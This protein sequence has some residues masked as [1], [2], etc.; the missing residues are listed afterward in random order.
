MLQGIECDSEINHMALQEINPSPER[1]K[2]SLKRAFKWRGYLIGLG[3]F[4]LATLMGHLV[5]T[6]FAP[7]NI[8]MIYLLCVTV[9]AVLGGLGPSI[10]VSILSA[11]TFDFFFITPYLTFAVDDTQYIF[12]FIALLLVGI[13]ISYLTSRVRQQTEAAKLRE[14]ETAALY[15]LGRD[16]A[17]SGDLESYIEAI[18]KRIKETLGHDVIIFLPDAQS[19][20]KLKAYARG[21]DAAI[22]RNELA[23]A[24]WSFQNQREA[25]YGTETLSN[26]KARYLPLVTVRGAIGVM[27]LRAPGTA[28]E[29]SVEQERLLRAY[30]DLV[31]VA[32]EGIQLADELHNAQVLKATEKLQAALLNAISHDLRTPLV[33]VIGTLS[34]LQEEGM[35]LDDA[36]KKNLIQVAREEADRLNHLITNLLDESRIE[37]GAITLSRQP[38]EVQD[39]VGAALEQLGS[40]A[41]TRSINID[42]PAEMPYISV[43]FGLIV[44]TLANILDNA[45]K[46]SP[47]DSPIE[48]KARQLDGDIHIEITDHGVGIPEQDLPHVFDKFHRIKRPDNVAGTGLG[49][50]ISKGIVEA[51][52]GHIKAEKGTDG[53]TIIRLTLPVGGPGAKTGVKS[54]GQ[55]ESISR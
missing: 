43:D 32:I 42:I 48:I 24:V 54:N 6:F 22:D 35:G 50:S 10:M 44:Q 28:S 25:G 49:L 41:S 21:A 53:G 18:V 38:S 8:I 29:L 40:R 55:H 34:S 7:T 11:L 20:G 4:I 19:D 30:T 36:V 39:L 46:Y 23:A 27:A 14:R 33:S 26:A 45:M 52:G 5:H 47:P 16:L 31:A 3:L 37:A 2:Q 9:S 12:T 1:E 17:V 13:I 15:A 51:H